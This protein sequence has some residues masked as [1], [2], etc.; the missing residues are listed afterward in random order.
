[1]LTNTQDFLKAITWFASED[2]PSVDAGER[3]EEHGQA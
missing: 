2:H 3:R 1:M